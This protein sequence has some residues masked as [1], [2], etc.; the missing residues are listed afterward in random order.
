[1]LQS[2]RLGRIGLGLEV[3]CSSQSQ[4]LG[5][6]RN[7]SLSTLLMLSG[8][9]TSSPPLCPRISEQSRLALSADTLLNL[10][11][12]VAGLR[13]A[14]GVGQAAMLDRICLAAAHQLDLRAEVVT[15]RKVEAHG[16]SAADAI[17]AV[18][19]AE[20]RDLSFVLLAPKFPGIEVASEGRTG[21]AAGV[22]GHGHHRVKLGPLIRP[23]R[24]PQERRSRGQA[25][26]LR[27]LSL[28]AL[29][30]PARKVDIRRAQGR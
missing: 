12:V 20:R 22:A 18:T 10:F 5:P 25:Q 7:R 6:S 8:P 14:A 24:P 30:W 11:S 19:I 4:Q 16:P 15:R 29:A 1:M 27:P 23:R 26:P 2:G 13:V 3:D 21:H 17:V 28:H 9:D